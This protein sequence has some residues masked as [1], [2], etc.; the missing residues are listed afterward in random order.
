MKPKL[1]VSFEMAALLKELGY[2]E[3]CLGFFSTIN[4]NADVM[5]GREP[6]D[7]N[8]ITA[9]ARISPEDTLTS[10]PLYTQVLDW[11]YEKSKGRI[12]VMYD[13]RDGDSNRDSFLLYVI[14]NAKK[15][16]SISLI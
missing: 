15:M 10:A 7:Y 3:P 5:G 9:N 2:S 16:T 6:Q 14:E 4:G 13:P 11:L 1:F 8:N 12:R